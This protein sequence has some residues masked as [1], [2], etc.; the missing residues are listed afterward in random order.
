MEILFSLLIMK[1]QGQFKY[2]FSDFALQNVSKAIRSASKPTTIRWATS[3]ATSATS[4]PAPRVQ[5]E[6][7]KECILLKSNRN[8]AKEL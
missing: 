4:T 2:N 5:L 6:S 3:P 7:V 8:N 1:P